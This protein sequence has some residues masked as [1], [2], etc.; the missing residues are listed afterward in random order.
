MLA[1]TP[2]PQFE[3]LLPP[4]LHDA[5]AGAVFEW[6]AHDLALALGRRLGQHGGAGLVID[7]G[8]AESASGETLQAVGRHAF[9]DPLQTPGELD[10]TAHVDFAALEQAVEKGGAETVGPIAQG[11]WLARMGIT[12][13]AERLK[14]NASP[15]ATQ[16]IDTAVVRLAGRGEGEMGRL[17]KV[18][19]LAQPRFGP[20]PGFEG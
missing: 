8:H 13:R 12:A 5:P 4:A 7:Y 14:V 18:L 16:A 11:E 3:R 9:A 15:G 17:F 6:R 2:I 19:G 10:L 20:L 1:P